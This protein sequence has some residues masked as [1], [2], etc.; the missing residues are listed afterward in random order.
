MDRLAGILGLYHPRGIWHQRWPHWG[1]D[2]RWCRVNLDVA[3]APTHVEIIAPY[4]SP[5]DRLSHPHMQ[6]IHDNQSDR[7]YRTHATPVAIHDMTAMTERLRRSGVRFRVDAPAGEF[8]FERIW[9][10]RDAVEPGVY[11]ADADGGLF[12]EF[13]PASAFGF[14]VPGPDHVPRPVSAEHPVVR[15]TR[16]TMIVADVDRSLKQLEAATGWVPDGPVETRDG[17]RRARLGFAHPRSA[18]LELAQPL[19]ATSTVGAYAAAWGPGPYGIAVE[20]ESLDET[21]ERLGRLEIAYRCTDGDGGVD[22]LADHT[23]TLGVQ[24][25]FQVRGPGTA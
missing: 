17:V 2:A 20:V 22:V 15:V 19:D 16:R 21:V 13:V 6:A 3:W 9:L 7:W 14:P 1:L 8:G 10:G 24:L 12:L 23:Q 18:A 5:D 25:E 11:D 4:G